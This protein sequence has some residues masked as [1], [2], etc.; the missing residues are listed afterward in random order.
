[1]IHHRMRGD[2]YDG[3]NATALATILPKLLKDLSPSRLTLIDSLDGDGN[4]LSD[5]RAVH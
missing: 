5:F 3:F 1:M 2:G 4:V